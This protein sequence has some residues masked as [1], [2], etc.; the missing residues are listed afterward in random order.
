[1]ALSVGRH[2]SGKRDLDVAFDDSHDGDN[3]NDECSG[4][5][6]RERDSCEISNSN[7]S[8]RSVLGFGFRISCDPYPARYEA[9]IKVADFGLGAN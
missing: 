6:P 7:L 8:V 1:M 5:D 9:S 4:H 2:G 3:V